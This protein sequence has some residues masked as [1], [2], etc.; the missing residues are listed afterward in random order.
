[1]IWTPSGK[2]CAVPAGIAT[3]G[4]P[5]QLHNSVRSRLRR[6]RSTFA[7]PPRS[8]PIASLDN[9][10]ARHHPVADRRAELERAALPELT[11]RR[12]CVSDEGRPR[13]RC[14]VAAG[15]GGTAPPRSDRKSVV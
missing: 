4:S 5:K 2:P 1:M 13:A 14:R 3:A 6:I 12:G 7:G 11:H 9:L 8:V 15:G 10:A